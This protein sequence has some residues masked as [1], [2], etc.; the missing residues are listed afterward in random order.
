MDM[1]SSMIEPHKY[2]SLRVGDR[3]YPVLADRL[4]SVSPVARTFLDCALARNGQRRIQ[5]PDSVTEASLA[6]FLDTIVDARKQKSVKSLITIVSLLDFFD[7]P[8]DFF[9]AL[10]ETVSSKLEL[11][12]IPTMFQINCGRSEAISLMSGQNFR[13]DQTIAALQLYVPKTWKLVRTFQYLPWGQEMPT[14]LRP[15]SIE[16]L[17]ECAPFSS[18]GDVLLAAE[19]GER[20]IHNRRLIGRPTPIRWPSMHLKAICDD[21]DAILDECTAGHLED[22]RTLCKEMQSECVPY[23]LNQENRAPYYIVDCRCRVIKMEVSECDDGTPYV[24]VTPTVPLLDE[25]TAKAVHVSMK[26]SIGWAPFNLAI[27]PGV[28]FA[29]DVHVPIGTSIGTLDFHIAMKWRA[30]FFD[31]FFHAAPTLEGVMSHLVF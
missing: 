18:Y 2:M 1:V 19:N 10:D 16:T 30:R 6:E 12:M 20:W 15:Q 9:N 26:R 27:K 24:C 22:L 13:V 3:V 31:I 7:V 29:I 28:P 17:L 8:Y 25:T 4:A 23:L 5:L 11:T 14:L 21:D